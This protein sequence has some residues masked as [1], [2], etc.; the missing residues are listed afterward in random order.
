MTS[1][2]FTKTTGPTLADT[3]IAD[4][5]AVIMIATTFEA[6]VAARFVEAWLDAAVEVAFRTRR[7]AAGISAYPKTK[8]E[9]TSAA[10]EPGS[11]RKS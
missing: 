8:A 1:A 4:A 11:L 9:K 10:R 7:L 2:V 6:A 5:M 3:G